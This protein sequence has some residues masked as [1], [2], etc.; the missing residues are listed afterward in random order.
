MTNC[1]QAAEYNQLKMGDWDMVVYGEMLFMEN[2]VIGAAILYLTGQVHGI[3]IQNGKGRLLMALG[4]LMCG[5][6]SFI[7]FVPVKMP[8]TIVAEGAFAWLLAKVVYGKARIAVTFV[9]ITWV[10]GGISLALLM[11]TKHECMVSGTGIYTG[12][13]KAGMLAIFICLSFAAI[14]QMLKVIESKKLHEQNTYEATIKVG[15]ESVVVKAFVDTG[16]CLK[17]PIGG[18][19]VAI[20]DEKLWRKLRERG[21]VCG[22]RY[23]LIPYKTVGGSGVMEAVRS[24]GL[25]INESCYSGCYIANGKGR[26]D[27]GKG[28]ELIVSES[29]V[30]GII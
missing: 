4:S 27:I 3:S 5:L 24:S 22:E 11:V 2:A 14:K 9:V 15:D 16:N 18:K 6:F 26:F 21:C 20:A 8:L 13:L 12:D 7:V 25:Y 19:P 28:C 17:D 30:N 29:V 1:E 23:A 10:M